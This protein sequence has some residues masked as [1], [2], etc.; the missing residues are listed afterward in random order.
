MRQR[1]V[2]QR[3]DQH[4]LDRVRRPTRTGFRQNIFFEDERRRRF[5]LDTLS[6]LLRGLMMRLPFLIKGYFMI[7]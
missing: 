5:D 3:Y 4:D 7:G 6:S 1:D 2:L